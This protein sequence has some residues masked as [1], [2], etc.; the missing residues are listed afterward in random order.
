MVLPIHT[1]SMSGSH[2]CHRYGPQKC[3]KVVVIVVKYLTG[4]PP[5]SSLH[6]TSS[7]L[8]SLLPNR[9]QNTTAFVL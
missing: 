6:G 3:I 2:N 7:L 5:D 9:I 1:Q 4:R 8:F